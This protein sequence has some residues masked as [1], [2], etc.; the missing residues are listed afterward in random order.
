MPPFN[1]PFGKLVVLVLTL[2]NTFTFLGKIF[3]QTPITDFRF[4]LQDNDYAKDRFKSEV[5]RLLKVLEGHLATSGP[6]I[7]G[8]HY[9]IADIM[10]WTW[11]VNYTKFGFTAEEYPNIQKWVDLVGGRDAVKKG[12]S[13]PQ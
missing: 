13:L 8:Q 6:Y 1:G 9:T 7:V 12:N 10:N 2:D 4:S 5:K 3:S 11:V